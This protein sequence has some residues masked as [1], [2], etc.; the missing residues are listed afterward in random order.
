LIVSQTPLNASEVLVVLALGANGTGARLLARLTRRSWD[1]LQ[2][3]AG[4]SVIA[5]VKG[6][7][8]T[9]GRGQ[10]K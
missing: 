5:Q 3:A 9:P 10:Q 4:M 8:L 2:L 7:A 1:Q 6:V